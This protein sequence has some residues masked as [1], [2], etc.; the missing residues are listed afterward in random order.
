MGTGSDM[1]ANIRESTPALYQR[2]VDIIDEHVDS[3]GKI[4]SYCVADDGYVSIAV[5]SDE[6]DHVL[7]HEMLDELAYPVLDAWKAEP[8]DK[9]WEYFELTIDDEKF[10]FSF[11]YPGEFDPEEGSMDRQRELLRKHFGKKPVDFGIGEW[12]YPD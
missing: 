8:A 6:G 4:L 7:R 11:T 3:T 1:M 10:D 2:I 12:S 9:R 5:F